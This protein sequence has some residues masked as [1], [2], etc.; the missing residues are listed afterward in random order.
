MDFLDGLSDKLHDVN[1]YMEEGNLYNLTIQNGN[2]IL[3]S[4]FSNQCHVC[5]RLDNNE[6]PLKRCSRCQLVSYCGKNHQHYDWKDHK[7][8]FKA[9]SKLGGPRMFEVLKKFCIP[10]NSSFDDI[11]VFLP[12]QWC[13]K[14]DLVSKLSILLKRKL[15]PHESQVIMYPR[16]C[17]VCFENDPLMLKSCADCPQSSFCIKHLGNSEHLKVCSKYKRC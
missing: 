9:L 17:D 12:L 7:H 4:Y 3:K 6:Y 14:E 5:C 15:L 11:D 1:K 13:E 10:P 8:L 16:V 2:T